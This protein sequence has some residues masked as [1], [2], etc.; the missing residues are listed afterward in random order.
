MKIRALDHSAL[1]V[2]DVDKS[3]H[4][5]GQI[6]GMEEVPRPSSFNF[7][8]AWFRMGNTELHLI[9]EE[10]VGRVEAVEPNGYGK[11]ELARGHGTHSAYEV[12]DLEETVRYLKERDIAI[13]GGPRPRGDGIMQLYILDPDNYIVEL[14]V[15]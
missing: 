6:L 1:L 7:R 15:R 2:R 8:G 5:Y 4:F 3:R 9:E 10:E 11:A 13:V 12:D 14:F